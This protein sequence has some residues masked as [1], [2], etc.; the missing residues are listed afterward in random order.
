[1]VPSH[2][3]MESPGRLPGIKS[4]D[5]PGL[6]P[7]DQVKPAHAVR[8]IYSTMADIF[9]TS[10]SGPRHPHATQG[11]QKYKSGRLSAS[12]SSLLML[13]GCP[14]RWVS[15][16][17]PAPPPLAVAPSPLV[18]PSARASSIAG[19]A[20]STVAVASPSMAGR[21]TTFSRSTAYAGRSNHKK[22]WW[23]RRWPL[24]AAMMDLW[25]QRRQLSRSKFGR[26]LYQGQLP[27][28]ATLATADRNRLRSPAETASAAGSNASSFL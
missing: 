28:V 25:Q 12:P 15:L 17:V 5:S 11:K 6:Q 9:S 4:S 13:D 27:F 8:S 18:Q 26:P 10:T 1:M 20:D 2:F 21:T 22:P 3:R 24:A 23:L 14:A 7:Q 16:A 19:V